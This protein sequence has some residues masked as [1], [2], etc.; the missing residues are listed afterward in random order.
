MRKN[1]RIHLPLSDKL[2]R[3]FKKHCFNERVSMSERMRKLI[4]EDIKKGGKK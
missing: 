2:H 3:K 1:A 4:K